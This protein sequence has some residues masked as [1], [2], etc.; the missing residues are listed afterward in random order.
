MTPAPRAP[1]DRSPTLAVAYRVYPQVSKQPLVHGHDKLALVELGLASLRESLQGL[2]VAFLALLDGCP[3]EY[4]TLVL[5]NFPQA[6]IHHLPR[7]GNRATFLLQLDWLITQTHSQ[8]C[9]FAEDDYF[10]GAPFAPLV[11]RL[12]ADPAP[13][14]VTPFEHADYGQIALHDTTHRVMQDELRWVDQLSTRMTF[15][16]RKDLPIQ[17]RAHLETYFDTNGDC[18]MWLALTKRR[19]FGFAWLLGRK[20]RGKS[21][22]HWKHAWRH[23]WRQVVFGPRCTL[24]SPSPSIAIHLQTDNIIDPDRW[25]TAIQAFESRPREDAH[26]T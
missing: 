4:E 11:R 10:Y 26:G 16:A 17:T 12:W 20:A 13:C 6:Q 1:D 25:R 2:D 18:T 9:Y 5:R 24:W 21:R 3:A 8:T 14:F 15:L 7:V 22:R 23:A 19:L